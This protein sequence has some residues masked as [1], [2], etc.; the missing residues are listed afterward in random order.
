[1]QSK[2][3]CGFCKIPIFVSYSRKRNEHY[4]DPIIR[5]GERLPVL[6]EE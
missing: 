1:M 6:V 4:V 2:Y 3:M 5:D